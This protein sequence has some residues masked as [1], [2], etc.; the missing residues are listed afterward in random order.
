MKSSREIQIAISI[1]VALQ[2]WKIKDVLAVNYATD[3]ELYYRI[4]LQCFLI[5]VFYFF[6]LKIANVHGL[7]VMKLMYIAC[8]LSL[9]VEVSNFF[10]KK[11][12]LYITTFF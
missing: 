6:V 12:N 11:F 2:A 3:P 4:T 1:F 8:R 9:F 5:D 7:H 10:K